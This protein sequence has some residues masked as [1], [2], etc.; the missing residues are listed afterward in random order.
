MDYSTTIAEI[1]EKA[2]LKLSIQPKSEND[3]TIKKEN[4]HDR[5]FSI[6]TRGGWS[7]VEGLTHVASAF[8]G[9]LMP[10]IEKHGPPS[11]YLSNPDEIDDAC[12]H[13]KEDGVATGSIKRIV[14]PDDKNDDNGNNDGFRSFRA[15]CR[16]IVGQ[17]LA[18]PAAKA[19]WSRLLLSMTTINQEYEQKFKTDIKV[20]LSP[21]SILAMSRKGEAMIESLRK[22]SGLSRSK[23]IAIVDLAR[24]YDKGILSDKFLFG[25]CQ[26]IINHDDKIREQLMKVKGLGPWS[27]DM[28]LIFHCHRPDIL[29][30]GDLGVRKGTGAFFGVRGKGK[31]NKLC[32][33]KDGDLMRRLHEPFAPYRSLS[34]YY[35]W[36]LIDN[37]SFNDD[38]SNIEFKKYR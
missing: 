33:K 3:V 38:R 23:M 8:D 15:L 19:M 14:T 35:M 18:G 16:I 24:H 30:L 4:S 34:T 9:K 25:K 32:E 5:N 1:V 13:K 37:V 22:S 26:D 28:F 11:F 2:T 20:C 12:R 7:L 29:A 17:Q 21:L 31:N 10:L 6:M 27:C 36:K